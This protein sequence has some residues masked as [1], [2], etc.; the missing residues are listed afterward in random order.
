MRGHRHRPMAV[1]RD[2]VPEEG[3][4]GSGMLFLRVVTH[5]RAKVKQEKQ[6]SLKLVLPCFVLKKR[7]GRM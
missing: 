1:I 2:Q 4:T 3:K 7:K 5:L 6:R